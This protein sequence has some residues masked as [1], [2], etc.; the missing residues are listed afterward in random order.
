M[1]EFLRDDNRAVLIDCIVCSHNDN[2]PRTLHKIF[3]LH[4]SCFERYHF[5][6]RYI[7][8]SIVN[9]EYIVRCLHKVNEGSLLGMSSLSHRSMLQCRI[10]KLKYNCTFKTSLS[11]GLKIYGYRKTHFTTHTHLA[12]TSTTSQSYLKII[13]I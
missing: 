1:A 9:Y 2:L 13:D 6:K 10:S 3:H 12:I 5:P 7:N 11:L 8:S 4:I